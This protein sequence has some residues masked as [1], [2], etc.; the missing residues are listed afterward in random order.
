MFLA[1]RN[2]KW[3]ELIPTTGKRIVASRLNDGYIYGR[4]AAYDILYRSADGGQTWASYGTSLAT[5]VVLLLPAGD[6]E[7][8]IVGSIKVYKTSG[9]GTGSITK[10]EVLAIPTGYVESWGA[11]ANGTGKIVVTHYGIPYTLSQYTWLST[12]FGATWS[13]IHD[14]DAIGRNDQHM[15]FACFDPYQAGRIYINSHD[16]GAG[17]GKFIRYTDNDGGA[18][19][20]FPNTRIFQ[21]D[22]TFR[23]CQP[24]TCV[25]IPEGLV[26]GS[27]DPEVCQ[28]IIRRGD[29]HMRKY[30]DGAIQTGPRGTRGFAVYSQRDPYTGIVYTCWKQET[31]N[32][33]SF[34]MAADGTDCRVVYADPGQYPVSGQSGISQLPGFYYMTF[35]A[36]EIV[37]VAVKPSAADGTSNA[38]WEFR[39][40]KAQYANRRLAEGEFLVVGYG[41]P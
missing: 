40:E 13:V 39:A 11:D 32:G 33:R 8:I 36:R 2:P 20:D 17:S 3:T 7:V 12:D 34:I 14:L 15:H 22:G 35:T 28:Y 27:D 38:Y 31:L 24:T 19:A 4:M 16:Q 6:G 37:A 25:A 5:S 41:H 1:L 26:L 30:A 10:A 18:W 23:N 29:N 9:W 21:E